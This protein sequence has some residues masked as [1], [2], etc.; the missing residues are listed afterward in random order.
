VSIYDNAPD[1]P[2]LV[3]EYYVE[4]YRSQFLEQVQLGDFSNHYEDCMDF[5]VKVTAVAKALDLGI[6]ERWTVFPQEDDFNF[7]FL[8]FRSEVE[9]YLQIIRV[10]HGQRVSAYSVRL[11]QEEKHEIYGFISKIRQI[12]E[13]S[14]LTTDK[15]DAIF[16]VLASLTLEIDR[17]RT[18]FDRIGDSMRRLAGLSK[19]V[20]ET[21]ARPWLKY[22]W[23]FWGKIDKAKEEEKQRLPPTSEQKRLPPPTK[24]ETKPA[25]NDDEIPF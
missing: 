3:F 14:S 13:N 17:D 11:T 20:E 19:E 18:R 6:L 25:S 24:K 8:L 10:K 15:K 22:I 9:H 7:Q 4:I 2:E 21:G 12:I 16:A 5:L 1:D 23:A